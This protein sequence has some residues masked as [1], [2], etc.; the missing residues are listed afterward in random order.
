MDIDITQCMTM[1]HLIR[2]LCR[3]RGM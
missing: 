2:E 3:W 1:Q